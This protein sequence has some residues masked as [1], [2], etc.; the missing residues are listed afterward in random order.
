MSL[1]ASTAQAGDRPSATEVPGYTYGTAGLPSAPISLEELQLIQGALLFGEEDVRY[2][3]MSRDVLAD[4]VEDVLDVWY[5]FVAA[6]PQLVQYFGDV[7]TGE[8]DAAYL[9]AVRKRF[10]QWILDTAEARYDQAWLDYQFEI[11]RRHHSVGK[12]RTDGVDSVPIIHFRYLAAL[13]FPITA[14]LR[15]FL[16][17]KGHGAEDVEKMQDAWRKAVLLQVILWSYPYVGEGEF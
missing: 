14:T 12:N 5:G 11:G 8:P 16:A 17:N 3:R 15:P 9:G 10:G 4:Q 6:T 1:I 13:H 2:L 7:R